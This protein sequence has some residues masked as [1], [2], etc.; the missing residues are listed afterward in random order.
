MTGGV[1][2]GAWRKIIGLI[3]KHQN[4]AAILLY[5][6]RAKGNFQ[7]GSDID[8]AVKGK[9][10]SSEQITEILL[11]YE[12][13]CLP[14]KLSVTALDAISNP[15]LLDHIDRVGIDLLRRIGRTKGVHAPR[16]GSARHARKK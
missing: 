6:S 14:W 5:G 10:I 13:L 11:A 15:S 8:L 1:P 12:D 7:K 9:G 4:V 3:A 2:Q 16:R